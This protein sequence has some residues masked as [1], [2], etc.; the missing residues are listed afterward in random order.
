MTTDAG[1]VEA[2][3]LGQLIEADRYLKE[4]QAAAAPHRR[5]LYNKYVPGG[6]V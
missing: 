4:K 5:I 1:S 3:D 6:T 2:Q